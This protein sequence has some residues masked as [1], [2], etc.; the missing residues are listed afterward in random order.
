MPLE[1]FVEQLVGAAIQCDVMCCVLGPAPVVGVMAKMSQGL[2][3]AGGSFFLFPA[4]S[5]WLSLSRGPSAS[6]ICGIG[7]GVGVA[8]GGG[9]FF[10]PPASWGGRFGFGFGF[11]FVLCYFAS[12]LFLTKRRDQE[13]REQS[14]RAELGA[15]KGPRY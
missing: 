9:R 4:G 1:S 15:P 14:L 2:L 6:A 12:R 7:I 8:R 13:S 3:N 10:F 11:G 5:W